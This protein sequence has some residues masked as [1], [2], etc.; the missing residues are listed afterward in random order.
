MHD[1]NKGAQFFSS[2]DKVRAIDLEPS[3]DKK[4]LYTFLGMAIYIISFG[5]NLADHTNLLKKS[6]KENVDFPRNPSHS[7]AFEKVK[8]LICTT[9]TLG[10]YDRKEQVVL[11][12]EA[13][14]RGLCAALFQNNKPIAFASKAL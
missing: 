10:Y 11:H 8:S 9:T 14:V 3:K 4:E 12:I 5:S 2:P 13:S 6:L 1:Q 7:K